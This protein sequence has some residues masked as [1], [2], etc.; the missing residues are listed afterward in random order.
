MEDKSQ[1]APD[2]KQPA[3]EAPK[4]AA[5]PSDRI[6][7]EQFCET[8]L[9]V[10]RIVSAERVENTDKLMKLQIDVGDEQRQIVAGIAQSYEPEELEGK[11]I[12]V[13]VNLRPARIRGVE[14]NG[15]LLAADLGGRPILATFEEEVA[16]G[17][18]VR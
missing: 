15:M 12:V 8:Q 13:V 17:T 2:R 10:A 18:R 7:I 5:E 6:S 16:P 14:S 11:R 4:P 1:P 9:R 3:A